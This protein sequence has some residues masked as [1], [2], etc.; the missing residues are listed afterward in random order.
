MTVRPARDSSSSADSSARRPRDPGRSPA[1]SPNGATSEQSAGTTPTTPTR[2]ELGR[3][4]RVMLFF[5]RV[6]VSFIWWDLIL[7]RLPGLGQLAE[8]SARTR[9]QDAAHRYR[10]LAIR[11]GGVLIK[12]GQFLSIRVDI[13]PPEITGE[14][15]GLQDEVPPE[16]LADIWAVVQQEFGRAPDE[17]YAWFSPTPEAAASLAQVHRA[18]LFS[19]IEVVV[20]VQRPRIEDLVETDLAA[21]RVATNWLKFYR[22]ITRRVDL[23]QV[24]SEFAQTTRAELD[25]IREG[26]N[27]VRFATDFAHNPGVYIPRVYWEYTTR[28]VLTMENVASI[29]ITDREAIEAAGISPSEVARRLYVT[30]L[31]QIFV[32]NFVHADP[33]PG[34]LFV[35]PLPDE[36]AASEGP[37]Q[38]GSTAGPR[39]DPGTG[40]T[41]AHGRPFLLIFVDFG[42]VAVIPPRLRAGLREYVIGIGAHDS[43]RVV[44]A[45]IDAGVL[46]PG[47]DRKRLEEVHDRLFQALNGVRMGTLSDVAMAQAQ[48]LIRE[49]R[50]LLYELPFQFPADMLFAV[51]AVGIL[52]GLATT[53]DPDF[54]PWSETIPFAERIASEQGAADWRRWLSEVGEMTRLALRLPAQLDRLITGAQRGDLTFQASLAPD[55][56]RSL[57][58][59]ARAVDRLTWSVIAIG[60]LLS[61]IVLRATEGPSGLSTALL[62]GAGL[63]FLWSLSRR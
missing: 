55:A 11:M 34:N 46:R 37:P 22:P 5:A 24:F 35:R 6:F 50:D 39:G 2:L 31:E 17:V 3:Y 41:I 59:I 4:L 20:K 13:L 56:A 1:G 36:A 26:E 10:R 19:G 54:D 62:V 9:W 29:K 58:R 44:Q 40:S 23:D 30:Y 16:R 52:S 38:G 60:L 49:Y 21:I 47:A 61:G 53:L 15:A 63:T 18:T 45:Y 42:M 8:R 33:H 51:R 57:Q 7:R 12:L 28:R 48:V 27:A 14:L 25:F 32:N 43:H